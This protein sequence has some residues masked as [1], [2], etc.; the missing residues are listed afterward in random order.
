MNWLVVIY[1][2]LICGYAA[3]L[4]NQGIAI[5]NHQLRAEYGN[6]IAKDISRDE[7]F[8]LSLKLSIPI[9]IGIMLPISIAT[10]LLSF[11]IVFLFSDMIGV[12]FK[13]HGLGLLLSIIFGI[14]FG[15]LLS[16]LFQLL[17]QFVPP[18]FS[19]DFITPLRGVFEPL[20]LV[21]ALIPATAIGIDY[22]AKKSVAAAFLTILV[23]IVTLRFFPQTAIGTAFLVG[24][25]IYILMSAKDAN[26]INFNQEQVE[27]F[28]DNVARIRSN[29]FYFMIMGSLLALGSYYY[30]FSTDTLVQA[31]VAYRLGIQ[32]GFVMLFIGISVIPKVFISATES[33]AFNPIGFGFAITAGYLATIFTGWFGA[34][35]AIVLGGLIALIEA[36]SMPQIAE[37]LDNHK[38]FKKMA[39]HMRSSSRAIQDIA[40]FIGSMLVANVIYPGVG[41]V[42]VFAFWFINRSTPTR[43]FQQVAI[44]PASIILM[45]LVINLLRFLDLLI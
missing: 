33:G 8:D 25:F 2:S 9:I 17:M 22:G 26:V 30:V 1:Y 40:I 28:K 45:G 11:F 21:Y 41:Y 29:R 32:A 27:Q 3:F 5:F 20:L 16:I 36:K 7:L 15:A 4:S 12:F 44:G 18:F 42:F 23:Y 19:I 39:E 6:Y 37:L 43:Y 24:T 34:V 35:V 10:N 13:K 31:L 14:L 38:R